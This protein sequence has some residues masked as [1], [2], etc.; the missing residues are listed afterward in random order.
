MGFLWKWE[1]SNHRKPLILQEARRIG[2]TYSV[3]EF[4]RMH[5]ENVASFNFETFEEN[6]RLEYLIPILSHLAGQTIVKGKTLVVFDE[7]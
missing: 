7:I 5:Y 2:E 1:Q 6:I 4:G 3:L